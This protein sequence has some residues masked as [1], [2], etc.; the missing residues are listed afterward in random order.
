MKYHYNKHAIKEGF[1]RNNNIVKYTR[2]AANFANRNKSALKYTYN[3]NYD[4]VTW[5]KGYKFGSGG[6]Y[7]NSGRIV[8]FWYKNK[9]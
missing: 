6:N 5:Y 2:D 8:N 4:N 3:V 7:K 1:S 9:Y